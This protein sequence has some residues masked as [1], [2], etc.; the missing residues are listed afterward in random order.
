M[1]PHLPSNSSTLGLSR[2]PLPD[3]T[4]SPSGLQPMPRVHR[5]DP[6][7]HPNRIPPSHH[8]NGH[9]IRKRLHRRRSPPPPLPLAYRAWNSRQTVVILAEPESLYLPFGLPQHHREDGSTA[10]TRHSEPYPASA[11]HSETAPDKYSRPCH[12]SLPSADR[13]PPETPTPAPVAE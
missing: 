12:A 13:E 9:R 5:P 6:H 11:A 7:P 10:E 4:S 2:V 8:P 3:P 1:P